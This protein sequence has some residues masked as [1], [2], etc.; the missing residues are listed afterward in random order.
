MVTI[1]SSAITFLDITDQQQLSAYLTSNLSTIQVRTADGNAY[2]PSWVDT[3]LVIQLHAFLNQTEIDYTDS[4]YTFT[5]SVKDGNADERPIDG[6]NGRELTINTNALGNSTSGMLTYICNVVHNGATTVTAHITYTLVG[7]IKSVVFSVY[8]PDGTIFVNQ[9]GTLTLATEKYHG[10]NPITSGATY[11]WYKYESARWIPIQDAINDT[12]SVDGKD[13]FNT[14]SYKC[15]MTYD[16]VEYTDI[17]TLEDKS[18]IYT[19]EMLT[20]GGNI[21]KNGIGGSA[22]YMVVRKNGTEIDPLA[23]VISVSEPSTPQVGEYWYCIDSD[24]DVIMQK[25]YSESGWVDEGIN[26]PQTLTYT[27]SLMDKNGNLVTFRDNDATKTGK[28]IY[29]S[30]ADINDTSTLCCEVTME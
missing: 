29:I 8:A 19:S 9:T 25:Q 15:V 22:A 20:I 30:C 4:S 18:D 24:N 2:T 1:T 16:G 26:I 11:Q 5:W 27:W 23:G 12:L 21:F 14:A 13:V 17:I 3:P 28:V 7:E 6:A 10:Q